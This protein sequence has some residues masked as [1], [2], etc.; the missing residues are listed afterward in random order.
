MGTVGFALDVEPSEEH[1][2]ALRRSM[3]DRRRM[4][5]ADHRE[6]PEN[7]I[8]GGRQEGKTRLALRWLMDA[9]A[10]VNRV[11]IVQDQDA[12]Q[13]LLSECG[14]PRSSDRIV[15]YRRHL[16]RGARPGV[17][18][19]VDETVTILSALLGLHED[20]HLLT[21]SFDALSFEE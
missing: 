17:E 18:Y 5:P 12:A 10:G 16:N 19:G 13:M 15:G 20:P 3:K 4:Y 2:E 1:R 6:G 21:V 7:V 11:L 9:P 8:I 14:L